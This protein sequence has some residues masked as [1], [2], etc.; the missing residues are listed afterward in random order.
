MRNPA[1]NAWSNSI[2]HAG[3]RR[4][5]YA[6]RRS[7]GPFVSSFEEGFLVLIARQWG[8]YHGSKRS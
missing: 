2:A 1:G 6:R 8:R 3:E 7:C 5:R 4:S